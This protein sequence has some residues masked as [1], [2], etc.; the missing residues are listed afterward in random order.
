MKVTK[1]NIKDIK[2]VNSWLSIDK[3]H[4]YLKSLL[5]DLNDINNKLKDKG[6]SNKQI[7]IDYENKHTEYSPERVDPCPDF[8][9]TFTLRFE[10]DPYNKIGEI[11][12]LDELDSALCLLYDFLF[13]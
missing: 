9:G 8:H 12:N 1:D 5:E 3:A 7:F 13:N 11:M 4:E 6:D 2:Y 10:K